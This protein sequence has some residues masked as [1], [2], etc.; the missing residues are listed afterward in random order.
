MAAHR[1]QK[2]GKATKAAQL[3]EIRQ[4][5]TAEHRPG[6]SQHKGGGVSR[7]CS[8]TAVHWPFNHPPA[9]EQPKSTS[10]PPG[11]SFAE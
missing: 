3:L 6:L 5:A 2:F 11:V 7:L 1:V 4:A 9:R 10:R 8:N